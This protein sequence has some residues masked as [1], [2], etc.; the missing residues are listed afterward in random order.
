M[1]QA[2][3]ELRARWGGRDGIGEDKALK[4]LAGHGFK[5]SRGGIIYPPIGFD[6]KDDPTDCMGAVNFLCDEWDYGYEETPS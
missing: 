2:T 1:P 6:P 4:H 5:L 3:D